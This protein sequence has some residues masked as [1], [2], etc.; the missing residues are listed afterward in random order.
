MLVPY[1]TYMNTFTISEYNGQSPPYTFPIGINH[2]VKDISKVCSLNLEESEI[3]KNSIDF[4][5]IN[6]SKLF[7]Q[8]RRLIIISFIFFELAAQA[9]LTQN[10]YRFK[11][12]LQKH[13]SIKILKI[14][15]I[16]II[17]LL[18]MTCLVFLYL[19]LGEPSTAFKHIVE[20]NYFSILLLYYLLSRMLWLKKA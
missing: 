3:I 12:E 16:F 1:A 15:I 14:K 13:I 5:F 20:W 18:L 8:T 11:E 10:L 2:I 6:N 9:T 17:I 4:S 7:D 19:A